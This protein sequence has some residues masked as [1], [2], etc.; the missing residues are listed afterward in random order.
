[1]MTR[2]D[3]VAVSEILSSQG[4]WIPSKVFNEL[5]NEFADLMA[6]DNERFLRERFVDS[7]YE[8]KLVND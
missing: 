2:K 5:V 7:C 6:E 1:M 4:D 3:Y 8:W